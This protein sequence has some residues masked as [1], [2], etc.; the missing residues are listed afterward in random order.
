M[1]LK[2]CEI[3]NNLDE[4]YTATM[5][6]GMKVSIPARKSITKWPTG[7]DIEYRDAVMFKGIHPGYT[8]NGEF[9]KASISIKVLKTIETAEQQKFQCNFCGVTHPSQEEMEKCLK[10]HKEFN[11]KQAAK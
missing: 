4:D 10:R 5:N 6:D 2:L 1:A 3:C 8:D 11:P 9:K 7:R